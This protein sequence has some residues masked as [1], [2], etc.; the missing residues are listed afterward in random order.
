MARPKVFVSN[1]EVPEPGL[2]LLRQECEVVEVPSNNPSYDTILQH[3][4]SSG[5]DAIF[6]CS[7]YKLDAAVVDAAGPALRA[8]ASMSA[9]YDHIDAHLLKRRG[10]PFGNTANVLNDAVAETAVALVLT[11]SR[12][13]QEGRRALERGLWETGRPQFMLGLDVAGSTVGVVGLGGIGQAF[14]KRIKAFNIGKL[15]YS[16]HKPKPEASALGAEFVSFDELVRKS[17]IIVMACP[18]TAETKNLF[19]AQVFD[20]MKSTSILI[21]VGRG[22]CIDQEALVDALKTKKIW[23]AGLDVMVPEPI[24]VDHPL[25]SLDNCVL[26]PH[27]GSATVGT[28]AAMAVLA[29]KNILCALKGQPMPSPV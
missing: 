10:I 22:G 13:L 25:V 17:D 9:G 28:R 26:F 4:P 16:G 5:V 21:N 6:W 19:N 24:P 2:A 15:L 18:L 11:V 27:V 14:A 3:M 8:V 23:G 7:K 1:A 29:A 20:E 12:R